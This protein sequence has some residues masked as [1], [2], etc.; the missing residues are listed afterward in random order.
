[1]FCFCPWLTHVEHLFCLS[2]LQAAVTQTRERLFQSRVWLTHAFGSR[3]SWWRLKSFCRRDRESPVWISEW[4]KARGWL[5]RSVSHCACPGL[6]VVIL[7]GQSRGTR[8]MM[9]PFGATEF[10]DKVANFHPYCPVMRR[11]NGPSAV[12]EC[13][14]VLET[15]AATHPLVA[16]SWYLVHDLGCAQGAWKPRRWSAD[17][18]RKFTVQPEFKTVSEFQRKKSPIL[19]VWVL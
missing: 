8:H 13:A 16:F 5:R 14:G 15:P 12:L 17:A 7:S 9:A 19:W 4:Q 2:S 6:H 11:K 3:F 1:M 10:S 18:G